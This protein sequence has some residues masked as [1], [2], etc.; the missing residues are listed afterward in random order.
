L[1]VHNS[2]CI[3][4]THNTACIACT[5]HSAC[6]ACTPFSLHCVHQLACIECTHNTACIECTPFSLLCVYTIHLALR[7]HTIQHPASPLLPWLLNLACIF[8]AK[9][10]ELDLYPDH[11][12]TQIDAVNEWVEGCSMLSPISAGLVVVAHILCFYTCGP[13]SAQWMSEWRVVLEPTALFS[14]LLF[15]KKACPNFWYFVTHSTHSKPRVA[16]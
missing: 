2:A 3:E 10:P 8:T 9:H 1:R 13:R 11:L 5:H 14:L 4:C 16:F 12:R 6:I 7:V 15:L